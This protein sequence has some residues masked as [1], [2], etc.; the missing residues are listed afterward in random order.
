[1]ELRKQQYSNLCL[2]NFMDNDDAAM[3]LLNCMEAPIDEETKVIKE[4]EL[5]TAC[6]L[7]TTSV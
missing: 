2:E 4:L 5:L 1:M 7:L 3:F 6:P